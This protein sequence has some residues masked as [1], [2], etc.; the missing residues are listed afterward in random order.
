MRL[1]FVFVAIVATLLVTSE[2]LADS[3]YADRRLLR[4]HYTT[5]AESEERGIKDIPLERLNSLGKKLGIDVQRA[6]TDA[7]YF[8]RI[9]PE[10]MKKYQ[11]KLNKLI[12]IYRSTPE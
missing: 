6:T 1:S 10:V 11:K 12:Q 5:S 9:S 2:A 7:A 4:T 8:R 3:N